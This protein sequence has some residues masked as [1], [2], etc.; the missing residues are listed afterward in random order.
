MCGRCRCWG[1][2][3]GV[4]VRGRQRLLVAG[5]FKRSH[6]GILLRDVLAVPHGRLHV[7]QRL[8]AGER[9]EAEG[10]ATTLRLGS[11][12][13]RV[14]RPRPDARRHFVWCERRTRGGW[15]PEGGQEGVRWPAQR[16]CLFSGRRCSWWGPRRPPTGLRGRPQGLMGRRVKPRVLHI[17]RRR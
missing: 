5:S 11:H 8:G 9:R 6:E 12:A 4:L 3:P 10:A 16:R 17:L 2:G 15:V 1:R 13:G 14:R 7:G